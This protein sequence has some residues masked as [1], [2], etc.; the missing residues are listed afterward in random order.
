MP[1][2]V[3]LLPAQLNSDLYLNYKTTKI[4]FLLTV[5]KIILFKNFVLFFLIPKAPTDEGHSSLT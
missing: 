4:N 2:V 3:I 5:V 1:F